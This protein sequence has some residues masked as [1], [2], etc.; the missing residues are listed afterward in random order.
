MR[1]RKGK[2]STFSPESGSQV[3]LVLH[4]AFAVLGWILFIYFWRIVGERGLSSGVLISLVAMA[5]FLAVVII[6]TTLWIV[7]NLRIARTNRRV[8]NREVPELAYRRDK[9]GCTIDNE[10][11]ESLKGARFIEVN[12]A[13]DRKIYRSVRRESVAAR[14]SSG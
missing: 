4:V 6:S 14:K 8:G 2:R 10:D 7:H 13:E 12:V 11:F 3:R 1:P 5:V 9:I